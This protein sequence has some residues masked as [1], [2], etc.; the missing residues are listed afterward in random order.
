MASNKPDIPPK[1]YEKYAGILEKE[2]NNSSLRMFNDSIT[3]T[4]NSGSIAQP[5]AEELEAIKYA[6]NIIAKIKDG[7][8]FIS[9][10]TGDNIET[11]PVG[12]GDTIGNVIYTMGIDEMV[13]KPTHAELR[14]F[15]EIDVPGQPSIM[16]GSDNIQFTKHG[17]II[18]DA[19]LGLLSDYPMDVFQDK[20]VLVLKKMLGDGSGTFVEIDCDG[21]K[22]LSID[23][24]VIFSRDWVRPWDEN[25]TQGRVKGNFEVQGLSSWEDIL[26]EFSMEPF[27]ITG[28]DEIKF[29]VTNAVFDFSDIRSDDDVVFPINYNSPLAGTPLW[30][31]FYLKQFQIQLPERLTGQNQVSLA[32]ENIIIDDLGFTGR[33][34]FNSV[35]NMAIEDEKDLNGWAFSLDTFRIGIT[36]QQFE[37]VRFAGLIHVPIFKER[38]SNSSEITAADCFGYSAL[39]NIGNQYNFT[40]VTNTD[41]DVDMWVAKA[42]IAPNSMV[43]LTYDDV[44]D[45]F[46]AEATI[47]GR[48]E[49]K[50]GLSDTDTTQNINIPLLA[51][52]DL[53]VRN[54]PD[55]FS[56]GKWGLG[57]SSDFSIDDIN[58]IGATIGGFTM[59]L[60]SIK[61]VS[62]ADMASLEFAMYLNMTADDLAVTASGK[63]KFAGEKDATSN[64]HFWKYDRF[65][66]NDIYLNINFKSMT[67][68]EGRLKFYKNDPVYG[69]GFK[70]T[71][72]VDVSTG[73]S[74]QS[75]GEFEGLA[76]ELDV[77]AQFGTKENYRYFFVD[78]M[79]DFS[80][81]GGI[82]FGGVAIVGF[83]G[84]VR[85]RM[86]RPEAM[87]AFAQYVNAGV[88]GP[89]LNTVPGVTMSGIQ[90]TPEETVA[91]G[92]EAS[93]ILASSGGTETFNANVTFGME[94]TTNNNGTVGLGRIYFQGNCK[95]MAS[96][97]FAQ[98][99]EYE[100]EGVP[101]TNG[102]IVGYLA[103]DFN[104]DDNVYDVNAL[105]QIEAGSVIQGEGSLSMH[106]NGEDDLWYIKVGTPEQP[107]FVSMSFPG[108]ENIGLT[109]K[110]YFMAGNFDIP[111]V[112]P[113]DL[114]SAALNDA[115]A[116]L[117]SNGLD[118][119]R[120]TEYETGAGFA[121]GA[122]LSVSSGE[123]QFLFAY[124]E[125]AATVGFDISIRNLGNAYCENTGQQVGIDGW[126]A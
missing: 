112:P 58:N 69:T 46:F 74:N 48:M 5:F 40:I 44:A 96:M 123:R 11:F 121:F 43:E 117:F 24:D 61:T 102:S 104:F 1:D 62:E 95:I 119:L 93:V 60:D 45:E 21:F 57:N 55:Y 85:R 111:G 103:I 109:I 67:K 49:I 90:Y 116:A 71:L 28:M 92:L 126:Y 107:N 98:I 101:Q 99:P 100:V 113:P 6:R 124:Y 115:V 68:L 63:F 54:R 51:F 3:D 29:E 47:H 31:G 52:E 76:V 56:P 106:I 87:G 14:V 118:P 36:A 7:G 25:N 4:V 105:V 108:V 8:K 9:K 15:L 64:R 10:F 59:V 33:V 110:T 34:G 53:K 20:A 2:L 42:T 78:A 84:G 122:S 94:F 23:A 32:G 27:F 16:F 72:S 39:I 18:G 37:E 50:L 30:K 38:N 75:K 83:A 66:V 80:S 65:D 41:Y 86:A 26:F 22:S 12:I 89:T 17:G 13:L 73:A 81:S 79:A 82:D 120:G 88:D 19:K 114:G 70:S 91:L 125:I 97:D 77:V 35:P